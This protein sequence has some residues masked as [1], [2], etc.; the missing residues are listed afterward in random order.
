MSHSL[1]CA[2]KAGELLLLLQQV[3]RETSAANPEVWRDGSTISRAIDV[4][5]GISKRER[6]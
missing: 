3:R 6:P 1:A 5:I 4:L 2:E